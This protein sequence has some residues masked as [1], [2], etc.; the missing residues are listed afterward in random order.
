MC[1]SGAI[2][3]RS[4]FRSLKSFGPAIWTCDF[5]THSIFMF[6][7]LPISWPLLTTAV[8]LPV[9][10]M[11]CF[12]PFI[13]FKH[14]YR[15]YLTFGYYVF[16]VFFFVRCCCHKMASIILSLLICADEWGWLWGFHRF[17]VR[18]SHDQHIENRHFTSQN[19]PFKPI[20]TCSSPN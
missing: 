19:G 15:R 6:G 17:F 4:I 9:N 8:F 5:S 20:N 10:K 7:C 18:I 2:R 3:Y 14:A 12:Q 16:R 1:V 11:R 13:H